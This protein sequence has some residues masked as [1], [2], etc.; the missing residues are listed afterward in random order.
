MGKCFHTTTVK[1]PIDQVWSALANFHNL[2]WAAGVIESLE[3]IGDKGQSEVGA[4]RKLN[5]VISETL[6][7][8]DADN[9]SLT[10]TI[11]DGPGPIAKDAVTNYTGAVKLVPL[12]TGG[13]TFIEWTSSYE[14]TDE[15]AVG[16]FCNPIYEALLGKL[17]EHFGA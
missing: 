17:Q 10:Y 7:S 13:G 8:L 14:S 1:A 4:Q 5:G 6:R 12:T 15:G 3:P 2:D 9:H 11:D 16:E